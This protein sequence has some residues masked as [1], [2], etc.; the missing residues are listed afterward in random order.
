[1]L[2]MGMGTGCGMRA[3]GH[4]WVG[5]GWSRLER[6]PSDLE[7]ERTQ[8]VCVCVCASACGIGVVHGVGDHSGYEHEW[9]QLVPM[10][11]R[12]TICL[13][14]YQGEKGAGAGWCR[15]WWR[16][17][18]WQDMGGHKGPLDPF[19]PCSVL[20]TLCKIQ[21]AVC[22]PCGTPQRNLQGGTRP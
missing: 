6:F 20:A 7:C 3:H 13:S 11:L 18:G 2:Q 9:G 14:V 8:V 1:M 4:G 16:L 21:R 22:F 17:A 5:Q 19:L 12:G 15:P 10:R